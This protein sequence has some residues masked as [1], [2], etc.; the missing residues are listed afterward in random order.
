MSSHEFERVIDG[1]KTLTQVTAD[2]FEPLERRGKPFDR[3]PH[4]LYVEP[5]GLDRE[6]V[7]SSGRRSQRS[8]PDEDFPSSD[9]SGTHASSVVRTSSMLTSNS[10]GACETGLCFAH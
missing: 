7:D 8:A 1:D 2:V 6:C 9:A 3:V 4:R 5:G 10:V